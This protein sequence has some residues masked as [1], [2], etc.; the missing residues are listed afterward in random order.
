MFVLRE[1]AY[2]LLIRRGVFGRDKKILLGLTVSDLF[3]GSFWGAFV[4]GSCSAALS[5]W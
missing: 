4:R 1:L 2:I 5:G 3:Y